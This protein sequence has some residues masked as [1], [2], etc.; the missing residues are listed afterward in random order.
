MRPLVLKIQGFG[1]YLEEQ[2]IDF[3]RLGDHTLFLICGPTGSGKTT[4]LD[5]LCFALYDEASGQSSN[6]DRQGNDMRSHYAEPN[7]ITEVTLDFQLRGKYY[8]V[9][10]SPKYEREKLRGS[11]TT[12]EPAKAKLWQLEHEAN[13]FY[14]VELLANGV[15]KVNEKIEEIIGL[16]SSQFR[17]V[18]IIPQG[19][20]R[21]FLTADSRERENIL[22]SLFD[23]E[24][25]RKI[26][27]EL[28][29]KVNALKGELNTLDTRKDTLL[30]QT[31]VQSKQMLEEL[32]EQTKEKIKQNENKMVELQDNE[33]VAQK[34]LNK[35]QRDIELLN[36]LN[37]TRQSYEYLL[38]RKAELDMK[39]EEY[40]LAR[41]ALPFHEKETTLKQ[42]D[43]E[44]QQEIKRKNIAKEELRRAEADLEKKK[45]NLNAQ[46]E[47]EKEREKAHSYLMRL[48]DSLPRVQALEE[49]ENELKGYQEKV[50]HLE[51][52]YKLA[53]QELDKTEKSLEDNQQ[54]VDQ[55]KHAASSIQLH[56][57][58]LH[59]IK[60][61][62]D[63]RKQLDQ[64]N[65]QTTA[66]QKE[67]RKI[68][69]QL[70]KAEGNLEYEK[71]ELED[72]EQ[73][74]LHGQAAILAAS[75]QPGKPCPVCGSMEHPQPATSELKLPTEK[76]IKHQKQKVHQLEEKARELSR[77]LSASQSDLAALKSKAD[78]LIS[79]LAKQES[80]S[81]DDL[82]T[83]KGEIEDQL[84][85]SQEANRSL[86]A[87]SQRAKQLKQKRSKLID[88]V[89]T[90]DERLR[91]QRSARDQL[92]GTVEQYKKE[93]QNVLPGALQ[94][95]M[96]LQQAIQETE[97]KLEDMK[98]ALE[99]A[100][101]AATKAESQFAGCKRAY[102]AAIEA[103]Q[104][105]IKIADEHRQRFLDQLKKAGFAE[106]R[107]YQR[108]KRTPSEMDHLEATIK[109]YEQSLRSAK[110]AY[111][112]AQADAKGIAMPD[113]ETLQRELE[114]IKE[115]EDGLHAQHG[116]LEEKLKLYQEINHQYD[117]T[118]KDLKRLQDR[119]QVIQSL[120]ETTTGKN[121]HRLS[122]H[123]WVLRSMFDDALYLASLRLKKMS[124]GRYWFHLRDERMRGGRQT[125]L[126]IDVH[127]AFTGRYRH[128]GTLSGGESFL[129]ALSLALG[130]AESVQSYAGGISLETIFIDEGFGNLDAE[131]LDMAMDALLE[132]NKG[133]RL[134]GIISHVSD[135]REFIRARLVV[136]ADQRGKGSVA[137]L[138]VE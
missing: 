91:T 10:R 127:D 50:N 19:K 55:A 1:T 77:L 40:K 51:D 72:L 99:I 37:Q 64:A 48:R 32:I 27:E 4:I 68:S 7:D 62:I 41:L 28:R 133:G 136:K 97:G 126:D 39:R 79:N 100:L 67:I 18:V 14:E 33:K 96:K 57:K 74:W 3:T 84:K 112:E 22:E 89:A 101:K 44:A 129:A 24:L 36:K 38:S 103:C 85:T 98:N 88:R 34:R 5:A 81:L 110:D 123:R 65:Q 122:F 29:L 130:L 61:H 137:E 94:E 92:H 20:F 21:A 83:T 47:R 9:T 31:G 60:K 134:V 114:E 43:E 107:D 71:R 26:E 128:V 8:R 16:N 115:K 25:Y 59:D 76:E 105:R 30:E 17:Q 116:R 13:R 42:R 138:V 45:S 70:A 118:I 6:S 135:L 121:I 63:W 113:I 119:Y 11:G 23:T 93:L 73:R 117:R 75:L 35:A 82:M 131:S 58:T 86:E 125:G 54:A 12:T 49:S 111:Q 69:I 104:E 109:D 2:V 80:I 108:A 120:Y 66:A 124:N 15:N 132:L 95:P 102:Q 56:Q 53:K 52:Q 87:L 78:A 46:L 106:L 90:L